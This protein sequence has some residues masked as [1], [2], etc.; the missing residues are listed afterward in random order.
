M[1][2]HNILI[3]R[4][5]IRINKTEIQNLRRLALK[6][7]GGGM[8]GHQS[9]LG[10]LELRLFNSLINRPR[11]TF[12]GLHFLYYMTPLN[13]QQELVQPLVEQK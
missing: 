10:L 12:S 8:G 6:D 1:H 13:F 4:Y 7:P 3:T 11:G 9:T 5:A 2:L